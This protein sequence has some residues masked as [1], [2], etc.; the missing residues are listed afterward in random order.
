M[1]SFSATLL[2]NITE[3]LADSPGRTA[4]LGHTSTGLEAAALVRRLA[5][6]AALIGVFDPD[7]QVPTSGVQPW[8]TLTPS[9][10]EVLVIAA[11]AGKERLLLAAATALDEHGPLPRVA[12]AGIAHQEQPVDEIF[13]TLEAPALVPSYATGHPHTRAHLYDCLASAA[14]TGRSG[15]IV[16]LGAFKGGTSVWLA[17]AAAA[18]GLHDTPVIA[19]DSWDGFP[20]RRSLLDLY[21]HPRCIFRDIDAVRAYTAPHNIETGRG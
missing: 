10:P 11:D 1:S 6:E 19:F 7:L 2:R 18:L 15:A 14:T 9:S 4:I 16:E 12:L 20:P 5:G 3:L 8:D 21:E 13:D 17:K